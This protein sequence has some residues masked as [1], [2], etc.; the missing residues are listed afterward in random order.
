MTSVSVTGEDLIEELV[1]ENRRQFN[2]LLFAD[3]CLN[4]LTEFKSF[5]DFISVQFIN[6][7]ESEVWN[8]FEQLSARVD[9]ICGIK[10][11]IVDNGIVS[12][13]LLK[14][15]I[16]E[17]DIVETNSNKDK[18]PEEVL[19]NNSA[20]DERQLRSRPKPNSSTN[21]SDKSFTSKGRYNWGTFKCPKKTVENNTNK[22]IILDQVSVNKG[23]GDERQ[24]HSQRKSHSSTNSSDMSFISK[25]SYN[26]GNYKCPKKTAIQENNIVE[27]NSDKDIELSEELENT[28]TQENIVVPNDP[29]QDITLELLLVDNSTGDIMQLQL[30]NNSTIGS[31]IGSNEVINV[32]ENGGQPANSYK[33]CDKKC[34]HVF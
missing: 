28:V 10:K 32:L 26:W 21:G 27:N 16:E 11:L 33:C 14:T 13:E 15:V 9:N 30:P 18:T 22:D 24:L 4:V 34:A 6:H 3:K 23:I 20:I 2:E 25:G 7:L 8:K 5:I 19:V 17:N 1:E 31:T 12:K 29:N